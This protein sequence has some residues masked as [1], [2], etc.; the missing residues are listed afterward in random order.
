MASEKK[1]YIGLEMSWSRRTWRAYPQCQACMPPSHLQDRLLPIKP[2]KPAQQ[3]IEKEIPH[4][5]TLPT[6]ANETSGC[7]KLFFKC[8]HVVLC[9]YI[10]ILFQNYMTRWLPRAIISSFCIIWG[11]KWYYMNPESFKSGISVI[12]LFFF[13]MVT[14][15]DI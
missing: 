15:N 2:K 3:R 12:I 8:F 5:L 10:K 6:S 7:L 1:T 9:K 14:K 11:S 4:Q 13:I